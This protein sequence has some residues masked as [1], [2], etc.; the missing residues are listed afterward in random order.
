MPSWKSTITLMLLLVLTFPA[1]TSLATPLFPNALNSTKT[2]E[3]LERTY[4]ESNSF[5]PTEK[6]IPVPDVPWFNTSWDYRKA[7]VIEGSTYGALT[8]YQLRFEV[9]RSPG[10]DSGATVYCSYNCIMT[11]QDLRFTESDGVTLCSYWIEEIIT[12]PERIAYVWVKIPFIPAYPGNTSIFL[13]YGYSH[14]LSISDIDATFDAACDMEEGNLSD[15]DGSWGTATHSASGLYAHSGSYSLAMTPASGLP[16]SSGR[17]LDVSIFDNYHA[18]RVWFYDT[19]TTT[20]WKS[21]N[22]ILSDGPTDNYK[23]YLGCAG[24]EANFSY[25]DGSTWMESNIPRSTGFHYYE[26]RH[27]DMTTFLYVDEH[28][29]HTSI[30]LNEPSLD[31]FRVYIYRGYPEASYFDDLIVRKWVTPEPIHLG[32][33]L[34]E[35]L[36]LRWEDAPSNQIIYFNNHFVYDLNATP[37]ALVDTWEINDTINFAINSHGTITNNTYLFPG[38]YGIYVRVNSTKGDLLDA[39]F[40]VLV[41]EQP[42]QSDWTVLVYLDGDNDL[43]EFAF[44]DLNSMET[45]GST[46]DVKIIVLVDFRYGADA[47]FSG[48]RCYELTQDAD[49]NTIA[50]SQLITTLPSEPDMGDWQVLRDFIVIGQAYAPADHYLLVLWDHG[51]GAFGVCADDTS[52][53]RLSI[54]EIHQA[55][56]GPQVQHLDIVAFDACLMGQLEVAYEIRYTTDLVLF[57]EESIPLTGFPYEDILLNLTTYPE[58][59]PKALASSMVY[60]YITAYD[61]GGRYYDPMYNDICLSAIETS[62]LFSVTQALDQLAQYLVGIVSNAD[63]YETISIARAS[64]QGFTWANFIDLYSFASRLEIELANPSWPYNLALSL[65]E[66]IDNAVYE[67]LHLAGV[68]DA[69]GLGAVF[70]SYGTYQLALADDTEWDEFMEA[71]IDIGSSLSNAIPL[72]ENIGYLGPPTLHCGYLDGPYDSVYFVFTAQETGMYTFTLDAAWSQYTSDFD[73]YIYDD[74][75]TELAESISPSSS[76]SIAIYLSAAN[77]YYVEAYSYDSGEGGIGV[78]YLN[79]YA[80]SGPGPGPFPIF[81]LILFIFIGISIFFTLVGGVIVAVYYFQRRPSTTPP[82]PP[83]RYTSPTRTSPPIRDVQDTAKFC[84]YCGA[85]VPYGARYCPICGASLI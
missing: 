60:Y 27:L 70:G 42:I 57:S 41:I 37:E 7:H 12:S 82:T 4:P 62:H 67:E 58:S 3:A 46:P 44:D 13:Y 32:W 24:H 71:F 6:E 33:I 8:N 9:H 39:A 5:S 29:I 68:A 59:T 84:A 31:Q 22:A 26:F 80:P 38:I 36:S 66:A 28:L 48:A 83:P 61:V 52:N 85:M 15:W 30:R 14:A 18:Y 19:G 79:M 11:F 63:S 45:I 10:I 81:P 40:A 73:L 47:P 74:H 76:E 25:W 65:Y 69:H 49:L 20:L 55:L 53:D 72:T 56:S 77:T 64:S 16:N 1:L 23:V 75:G 51:A 54:P 78:F 34:T 50:S 17:F 21:T 35:L 2:I 43:E